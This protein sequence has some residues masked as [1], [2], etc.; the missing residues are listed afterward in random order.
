MI[1][2][3]ILKVSIR[4]KKTY[5]NSFIS[6]ILF[7]IIL[8][9]HFSYAQK[10][11]I[12]FEH[13]NFNNG[14]PQYVNDIFQDRVGYLWFGTYYGLY[15]FDGYSIKSY[16]PGSTNITNANIR[17]ICD[18][19]EGNI[20]IGHAHGLDKL[21]SSK[22]TFK[23]Y[24]LNPKTP[25]TDWRQYVVALHE[26]RNGNLWI[27]TGGGLYLFDKTTENFKWIKHDTTGPTSIYHNPVHAI[28]EDR[29]G[30]LWFGTGEGLDKL[31]KIANKFI[32]YYNEKNGKV[33]PDLGNNP[34]NV[35]SILEDKD[36]RFW[37]GT[38]GGLVEFNRKNET[39]TQ[40]KNDPKDPASI[41]DDFVRSIC[42]DYNGYLWISTD[43][44]L[45]IFDKNSRKFS[46]YTY[47]ELDPGS[48]SSNFT[49][50]IL[51]DRSG[52]IWIATSGGDVNKYVPQYPY[53]KQYTS[54]IGKPGKLPLAELDD[55][56]EDHNGKIW[57]GT[58]KGLLSFDPKKELFKKEFFKMPAS[59]LLFDKAGTLW[60]SSFLTVNNGNLFYIRNKDKKINRLFDFSGKLYNE[61][62]T[63]MCNS[64][65]GCIW[66]G[67]A[68]GKL[69]KLNPST[70][71]VE[72][73]A[74]YEH[75][76]SALYEDK[77]G[78]LWIGTHDGG[79]ICYDQ[80]E[81]I[82]KN[83]STDPKDPNTISGDAITYLCEDGTGTVWII[84]YTALNKFD[85]V[86]QKII[87]VGEKD[88]FP[89]E[90]F[91][92]IDDTR[93][94]LWIGT[95]NGLVKYN[96]FTKQLKNYA[97]IKPRWGYK[98]RNGE[99][100]FI[101]A[102]L[103]QKK[104]SIIRFYPD[105]LQVNSFIPPVVITSFKKFEKPYP[106][107]KEIKLSY[108]ENFISFE[109]AALSYISPEK[110]QY[111]YKMEGLDKEWVYS[112]TR[113]Y[114][115]YPN[116][117]PGEYVFRVKGS[118]ND[119]VWNEEGTSVAIIIS[120]PF[121][122]TWWAY[123]SY[124]VLF[125]FALYGLR[126]YELNRLSFKNR[127]ELNEVVLKEREET[128]KIKSRFFANI[129]HEFRT[130]LTLI[131]GP[132]EKIISRVSDEKVLKDANIIKNNSVRLLQLVNQ[133]L[134]LSRLEAGKLKLEASKGNIV[135]FVKG[136]ALSFESLAESKDIILKILSE[137]EYIELY[138]DKEKMTK[139]LT[140][141][142][143]NALK[144]TPEEGKITISI[145]ELTGNVEIKIRDTGMGI[146]R[147]EIPKLFN[148]FYQVDSS[149][150]REF[151]GTGI[152]LALTKELV[153]LHYG[154]INA[155]SEPGKWTEFTI[156]LPLGK[157]HLKGEEI[158]EVSKPEEIKSDIYKESINIQ[159]KIAEKIT[160]EIS[161]ESTE[162]GEKTIILI[163]EDNY[164]MREYIKDFLL[165]EYLVEEAVNGEQGVR[166]A[167]KIIPDLII[168]DMM[169][170][171]M[172]GNEL[173]R[174]L[175]NDEKT[176]HIPIILLTAKSGREN[177]LEGLKTG[178]DDYLTKPFDV[179]ELQIRIEN[180]IKIR[181]KLQEKYT[182]RDYIPKSDGKKLSSIDEIFMNK[183]IRVIEKH[184]AEEEFTIEELSL[185]IEMSRSQ[186]HRKIK[187]LTGK[188]PSVYMRTLR[189][190][191]AKKMIERKA[192][193]ISEIA[194]SVGFSS[195][196]YFTRCFKEEFSYPPSD[197]LKSK[198]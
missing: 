158:E 177:K 75:E 40:Y 51:L 17:A 144:F 130:P 61:V 178:A 3:S 100:Y 7:I 29:S 186:A 45:D 83:F 15:R 152:G 153:E 99:L 110:N 140:N 30:T 87:R 196:G 167:E 102:P 185:E 157:E 129:S 147:E 176:S 38:S 74:E 187:A 131:L 88:G 180:L 16:S 1:K 98:M 60:I 156:K 119:G 63:F 2:P 52:A 64:S 20:W 107:D 82:F 78:L 193:N 73:I 183:V 76:I 35:T 11:N 36:G 22:E 108:L 46:H 27:G 65:D 161:E 47:N 133:L 23:H 28:Y 124:S 111:A 94:N 164:D 112:G 135:S 56:V 32:H 103:F 67:T 97:L 192:G 154:N 54:E 115:S 49:G 85:R 198:T 58:D 18:D 182:D 42:E 136:I 188:S 175:K 86:K 150:T 53:L 137:K 33:Y 4:K 26:D 48:I 59:V 121:W 24:I 138:F 116:L 70:R 41:A 80:S 174:I 19:R 90:A 72:Q 172:D 184:L 127:V 170:P 173:T 109:F 43:R 62:V 145:M 91:N 181:R 165:N 126:R 57:I 132:A 31:D 44:G 6:I 55:L 106:F 13:L 37:L 143:S 104:Q 92:L 89:K 159:N 34:H 101:L 197:L 84:A 14:L 128:D 95:V 194:Y 93:G 71:K 191:R 118:N 50:K 69:L 171:K 123:I 12:T 105:S 166:K 142:L 122:K 77:T 117:G 114:A 168:S 96:P 179:K 66:Q 149:H 162:N 155:G 125:V 169:M 81:K 148:R 189:L 39:F 79:L 21:N 151:E 68:N 9:F 163:V 120:P 25:L 195:L 139:I 141:I 5:L 8:Q 134:D 10:S 113:R 160:D 146:A 190:L